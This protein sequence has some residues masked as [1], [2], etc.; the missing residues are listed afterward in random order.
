MKDSKLN[1]LKIGA[2][3]VLVAGGSGCVLGVAAV[4]GAGAGTYA[5]VK[6]EMSGTQSAS[7]DKTWAA[8]QAV[9]QE[10]GFTVEKKT[11]DGVQ[12]ELVARDSKNTR[13]V[14]S[15]KRVAE[16]ATEV[17]VRVGVFGDEAISRT[18]LD[19]IRAKVG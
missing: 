17:S 19:R 3:C 6:G 18:I 11:K 8:A 5:Y 13:I 10:L 4:A 16:A 2:L 1:W 15:L 9:V 12:A 14:I 7:L